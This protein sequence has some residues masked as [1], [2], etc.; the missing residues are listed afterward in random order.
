VYIFIISEVLN[1]VTCV[2]AF[3]QLSTTADTRPL[4]HF[5]SLR[6]KFG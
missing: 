6:L 1:S 3:F 5:R 2:T 4:F